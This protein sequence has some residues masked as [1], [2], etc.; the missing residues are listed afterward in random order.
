LALE[1]AGLNANEVGLI[2]AHGNGT[3][4][5]DA[6]EAVAINRVFNSAPPPVTAFK[7]AFGHLVAASASLDILLALRALRSGIVP[8]VPTLRTFDP[9]LPAIPVSTRPQKPRSDVALILCRGF[10]AMNLALLV[11]LGGAGRP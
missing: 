11:R 5:S 7:W 4:A 2:I 8:G 1:N 6:S 3:G 9:E 10:A